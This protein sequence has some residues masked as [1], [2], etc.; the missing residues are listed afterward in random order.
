MPHNNATVKFMSTTG[1]GF[2]LNT[3]GQKN[4]SNAFTNKNMN[5]GIIDP[6]EKLSD[7]NILNTRLKSAPENQ[8]N[9]N[10]YV[11]DETPKDDGG[12]VTIVENSLQNTDR[13]KVNTDDNKELIVEEKD[14]GQPPDPNVFA[15]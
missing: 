12:L 13:N 7:A 8:F 15:V 2:G 1:T 10:Q 9:M 5:I 3:S 4:N 11:S 14:R 6:E